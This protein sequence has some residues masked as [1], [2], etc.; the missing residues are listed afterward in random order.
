MGSPINNMP[1]LTCNL[2]KIDLMSFK[3][4]FEHVSLPVDC[5]HIDLTGSIL[6]NS[7]SGFCYFLTLVGNRV[8]ALVDG[9]CQEESPVAPES[10]EFIDEFH[11]SGTAE[12]PSIQKLE[13]MNLP[14]SKTT[15]KKQPLTS[16]IRAIGP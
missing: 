12:E 13:G 5:V 7:I 1:F 2:N 14:Y 10:Q 15:T 9:F 6:P 8:L 3:N 16:R 11:H 4:L